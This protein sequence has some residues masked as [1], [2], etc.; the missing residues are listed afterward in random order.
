MIVEV[1][2]FRV[3]LGFRGLWVNKY[4]HEPFGCDI[5]I[6]LQHSGVGTKSLQATDDRGASYRWRSSSN[7]L[8]DRQQIDRHTLFAPAVHVT[9]RLKS[10]LLEQ[11]AAACGHAPSQHHCMLDLTLKMPRLLVDGLGENDLN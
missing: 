8:A 3:H 1:S 11:P 6:G 4:L 10:S 7:Y 2:G 5:Y 9:S